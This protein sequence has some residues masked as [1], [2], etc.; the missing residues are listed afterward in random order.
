M[1]E[2]LRPLLSH[3]FNLTV[4][5]PLKAITRGFSYAIVPT[6]WTNRAA[7]TSKLQLNEM[8]SRYL[9]IVLYVFLEDHLSR[10]DYRRPARR[11]RR[12]P[13]ARTRRTADARPGE[14]PA[15]PPPR[16]PLTCRTSAS[17]P[18][19]ASASLVSRHLAGGRRVVDLQ[20]G[21]AAV[22]RLPERLGLA[23]RRGRRLRRRAGRPR[24]PLA[25]HPAPDR[26]P[27]PARRR[28]PAHARRLHGQQRAAAAR[29]RG[30]AHRRCSARRT[31]ARG[32]TILGSIIAERLLDA[33]VLA[34]L[35]AILTW[36]N[37][38]ARPGRADAGRDRR[39]R[40]RARRRSRS[41]AT[42]RCAAAASSTPS[43]RRSGRSAR[44]QAVRP[45]RGP[46]AGRADR[47]RLVLR[48]AD[49][50]AD[51]QLARPRA[52]PPRLAA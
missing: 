15:A 44:A 22:P 39:R 25:P 7:G 21:R 8:G 50:A 1:I 30:P 45:R 29:R 42:W 35:F 49:A 28:L 38:A 2:N 48:G 3:H 9:F 52:A 4:E 26:D 17:R 37:V 5:L 11:G 24:L 40:A 51:R 32:A 46:A 43:T 10:G 27:A 20:P 41:P 12:A 19:G 14:P 34:A 47:A 31:T 18:N 6:S 13:G 33:A 36:F 16:A 23:G